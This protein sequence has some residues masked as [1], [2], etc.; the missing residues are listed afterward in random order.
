MSDRVMMTNYDVF[1]A[2]QYLLTATLVPSNFT[3]PPQETGALA[4]EN[5]TAHTSY[6]YSDGFCKLSTESS[7]YSGKSLEKAA[8]N[9]H[10]TCIE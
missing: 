2:D 5:N 9:C 7:L 3:P 6:S 4:S 10:A 8:L 1:I